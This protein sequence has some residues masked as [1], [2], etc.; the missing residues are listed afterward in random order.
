MKSF[1]ALP[2]SMQ[3]EHVKQYYDML[4]KRKFS[5]VAKRVLDIILSLKLLAMLSPL[6]VVIAIWIQLDSKG[7]ILY[8]QER[9]TT[10]G[11]TF[12]IWKFRTMISDADKKGT[13]ITLENDSRITKAGHFLRKYRLDEIPQLFNVLMG[14]MSFV[15]TRPEVAK[16]VA[17]YTDEMKA[18]LLL[19]AGITSLASIQYKDEDAIISQYTQQG[20][21]VDEVYVQHVL[22]NKMTYN[23]DYLKSFNIVEDLKIMIDTLV[24][25]VK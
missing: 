11:K 16:Y 7:D 15:G 13:L 18:T 1:D 5:R 6:I 12:K 4:Q 25:V 14:D 8:K 20:M 24:N 3:N 10:Y 23:L 9:I 22:P 2:Q 19:P 17:Q 21:S